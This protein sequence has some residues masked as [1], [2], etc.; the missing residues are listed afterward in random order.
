MVLEGRGP[1]RR[2][3][4]FSLLLILILL[5]PAA[6]IQ[7]DREPVPAKPSAAAA[8]AHPLAEL[9][10]EA[11]TK[12]APALLKELLEAQRKTQQGGEPA[13]VTYLVYL[14]E[15]APLE[16]IS[17]SLGKEARRQALVESLQNTAQ[18]SQAG[19]VRYLEGKLAQ[20]K[21]RRYR[22][23]WI[24]NGLAVEGDLQTALEL[25]RRP[26]VQALLPN[27]SHQLPA[28]SATGDQGQALVWNVA[29]IGADRVWQALGIT[30]A[31]VV[32][33]NLDSGVDWTH[34]ALQRQ[35]RGYNPQNP[36][37]SVHHYNWFDATGTYPDAPGPNRA[38]ISRYSDHGT[39]TMGTLVGSSPDG[40]NAIGV[41][42]GARWIAAKVFDDQGRA[43]D[44]WIHAGFQWVLAPTDL[45]G[46]NPD[47]SRA[48]DIVS[49]SWGDDNGL[50][51]TFRQD[52]AA[53]RAA[54]IFTVFSAG[55]AGP[56]AGTIG[57]PASLD[58]A[59]AVGA[60]NSQDQI[61]SF[62]SRGP[63]PWGQIKPDL[64]APG[65]DIFSSV[66]GGGY[67]AGWNGTSMATPHV[68][69]L[70]A[71]LWQADRAG[72]GLAGDRLNPSLTLTATIH[73]ITSTAVD[74]GEPGKDNTF[75][76]GRIDAYQ[77]VSTLVQGGTFAGQVRDRISGAPLA[78]VQIHLR[79]LATGGQTVGYT[80][81]DGSYT[82]AIAQGRYDVSARC[83]GYQEA[84]ATDIQILARTTTQLDFALQ[85][86][87]RGTLRGRV[88]LAGGNPPP[89]TTVSLVGTP[90]ST[91]VDA[92]GYYT[93][94]VPVG[95]YTV[96]ALPKVVGHRGAEARGIE[97]TA[98]GFH[99]VNLTLTPAPKLLLV[100]ADAWQGNTI[101]GYYRALLTDLLYAYDLHTILNPPTDNP[102]AA[103][104]SR[105]DV[106]LWAQPV[107]SP[108]YIGAWEAL[109]A[110]LRQGGK[111]F[112]SG[113]DI[114]YWDTEYNY[115]R[116]AYAA[117]LHARYLNDDG[118]LE[119]LQGL[120][121]ELFAGL[122]LTYNTL[123]SARNQRGPDRI[124]PADALARALIGPQADDARALRS[125][126]CAARVVYLSFGLEGVGPEAAR[127][128]L[129]E[130]A[131]NWLATPRPA[132]GAE[133]R[134]AASSQAAVVG[135]VVTYNLF[136]LNGGQTTE[137]F[138]LTV[139]ASPWPARL[140]DPAT[141][142]TIQQTPPLT[143]CQSIALRLEVTVPE[144]AVSNETVTTTVRAT[145]LGAPPFSVEQTV[146]TVAFRP[147]R[148]APAL[149]APRYLFALAATDCQLIAIGGYGENDDHALNTVEILDLAQGVWRAGAPKPTPAANSGMAQLDGRIFV[150]GGYDPA[151][152][153]QFL[154]AV[155]VYDPATDRWSSAA[156]LPIAL[157]GAAVAGLQG[158]LYV[159]GGNNAAGASQAAFVYD[160][161]MDRWSSLSPLPGA[162]AF[163]RAIALQGALY[164]VG[165]WPANN[166]LWR[167][168]PAGDMWTVLSPMRVGRHSPALITDGRYLYVAGGGQEWTGLD[169]VE[170]YDPLTD[171]W[172]SLPSLA[173]PTR[174]GA[175]GA[176]LQGRFY[177]LGG[178]ATQ[179]TATGECL[180]LATPLSGSYVRLAPSIVP[181]GEVVAYTLVV[182]NTAAQSL[183]AGW[184]FP[185][186]QALEYVPGSANQGATYDPAQRTL[187]WEGRLAPAASSTFTFRATVNPTVPDGAILTG[188][189][190][191]SGEA[192]VP[193]ELVSAVR[194]AV[195]SLALST[196]V[197]D[198]ANVAPGG[199]LRYTIVVANGSPY[200]IPNAS[201]VDPIPAFTQYVPGS[202][203]G[204]A[205]YNAAQQRIEWEGAVPPVEPVGKPF[206]W[207]DATQGQELALSDDSCVGPLDLGFAFEFYGQT[208][209]QIYVNSN[210]MVLLGDCSTAYRN[211]TIPNP[212]P[213]NNFIAPFWDDLVPGSGGVYFA[214]FGTAPTRYA[215]IEW[216]RVRF[217]NED[218]QQTFEVVL[219][220]GSNRII[221]QYLQVN[222]ARGAGSSATIGLENADGSAG[223]QYLYN[224]EP[225]AHR[226]SPGLVIELDHPSAR[227]ASTRIISYEVLVQS[228][229]PPLTVIT[230]TAVIQDGRATHRRT[231]TTTV[232]SPSFVLSRKEAEPRRILS[233]ELV[234][235]TLHLVNSGTLDAS[236]A[237]LLDRLPQG[238]SF[239][240][241]S[242]NPPTASYNAALRR[243]E[244][245]GPLAVDPAGLTITYRAQ[246]DAN[247]PINTWLTNTATLAEQSFV[248][249][250]LQAGVLVNEVNLASSTMTAQPESVIAGET[251]TY[252]LVLRN[253]GLATAAQLALSNTLPAGLELLPESV[254]GANY[255]LEGR[256]IHWQGPLGP[257]A[258]H[259]VRFRAA[260]GVNIPDGTLLTNTASLADGY[261]GVTSLAAPVRVRRANLAASD[262][263]V[264]PARLA[265]G[266]R[267]TYTLRL[268]NTGTVE[269][270]ANLEST[271]PAPLQP[272]ADSAYA[273]AGQVLVEGNSLSWRGAIR[274][275][276]MVIVRL[277]LT[278]PIETP[279][280]VVETEAVLTDQG[281][282]CYPLRARVI[283]G[284]YVSFWPQIYRNYR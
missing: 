56:D 29:K 1:V 46:R 7:A 238:L 21:I 117:F 107:A 154:A 149:S 244:W 132:R 186:P 146:Q 223:V 63:S 216:H 68:A 245:Q 93:L 263:L 2:H 122:Q 47:P 278:A 64:V 99:T 191:L 232:H 248:L 250:T 120:P 239:V 27:R 116:E 252:T 86:L 62:S 55:N 240:P 281:G 24:F 8:E 109:G 124:A 51:Q 136:L 170:R 225:A 134:L 85:P 167:Y 140:L 70:A 50:D 237:R 54:G 72:G 22:S 210:G 84:L 74:L 190:T 204:G 274:P 258:E 44:E 219:Y 284:G 271:F 121:E 260:V 16:K 196:K 268:R 4:L 161:E 112:L 82:I 61:A 59:L 33:A 159:V 88:T 152:K 266:G 13:A 101:I 139:S 199:R 171:R 115:A 9:P 233:G 141:G 256:R 48:P 14:R 10:V 236:N 3:R 202:L 83:F 119:P 197:V 251:V 209:R 111:L 228:P 235:F 181:P 118:G 264:L 270:T 267:V 182:R 189:I 180:D 212:D 35:Y 226:I 76:Y 65:V 97:I 32:V 164:V 153:D 73:L 87:P 220:E 18:R 213:P 11:R 192:C 241:G 174:A 173:N 207:I 38:G 129:L 283:L 90:L 157:S 53:L 275:Q 273:T 253:T 91:E 276:G 98:E 208:Y 193:R 200:T 131:L 43:T 282:L 151:S 110:F 142:Q 257:G 254:D 126:D 215:V 114:G 155:E 277:S 25:A 158:K 222:G 205:R 194:V 211:E 123:D 178:A 94:T 249:A 166:Q 92:Q 23:Y 280:G 147:W 203:S 15:Q 138:Q 229:L 218:Q 80:D 30:G 231:V 185:L 41:A 71:L 169:S 177:V 214:V 100:D 179:V 160:P 78:N 79:N 125:D 156:P 183:A 12:I 127:R 255:D 20:G 145:S 105:Y 102:S 187:R 150:V 75:G 103:D 108:G 162:L 168:D 60:T 37:A 28:P 66:A 195:P 42:P 17:P 259:R 31:G 67:E 165:G 144:E 227:R 272:V 234:T 137:R 95:V 221:C 198:Q 247:L 201:L 113:Q 261:G 246:A 269:A 5:W 69:G 133:F 188:T 36:A 96:R 224:G 184:S 58:I 128:A 163:G 49:N 45:D 19:V 217:Y 172:L 130:R 104:L 89:A 40:E 175:G 148:S 279:P 6:S 34:P 81:A 243:I 265:P 77:A 262:V 230:N 52:I 39:H 106:V 135:H 206:S 26:D 57:S 143:P 242:L 176:Y